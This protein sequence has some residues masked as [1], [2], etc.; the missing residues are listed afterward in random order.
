MTVGNLK[1]ILTDISDFKMTLCDPQWLRQVSL[2]LYIP[3]KIT[4]YGRKH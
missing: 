3:G 2:D 1:S 4:H